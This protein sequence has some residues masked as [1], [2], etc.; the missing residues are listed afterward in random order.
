M[1]RNIEQVFPE[2][3]VAEPEDKKTWPGIEH[4][5]VITMDGQ[6]IWGWRDLQAD[7]P[8]DLCFLREIGEVFLEGVAAGL[9][10]AEFR[11]QQGETRVCI[12]CEKE[13]P[14]P[15]TCNVTT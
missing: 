13:T 3:K 2:F 7:A 5:F 10:L 4:E 9:K 14:Q 6:F 12:L 8:E 11:A 15:H 1:Y